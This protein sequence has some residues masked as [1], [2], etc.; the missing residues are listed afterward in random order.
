MRIWF[1]VS[2]Q[3]S[4]IN[5]CVCAAALVLTSSSSIKK[6]K[7]IGF[8]AH[9]VLNSAE[10]LHGFEVGEHSSACLCCREMVLPLSREANI[11][12]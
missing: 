1:E 7:K 6:K 9:S 3:I 11:S 2:G 5:R 8:S 12:Q 4:V 10:K